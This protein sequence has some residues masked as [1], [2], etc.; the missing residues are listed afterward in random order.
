MIS[1]G[2]ATALRVMTYNIRYD[3]TADGQNQWSNRKANVFQLIKDR[4]PDLLGIQEA[5]ARQMTDLQT[6]L[7]NYRHYGVGRD[8]GNTRGEYSAIFYRADRFD[9]LKSGTFWLSPT[10]TIV[11]SKGWDAAITRICSW[12]Q[13]R[14]KRT[15]Q[16]LYHFNTHYDHKGENARLQS[17]HL[18]LN[19]IKTIAGTTTPVIFTGDLNA[20]PNSD[21][22]R[23]II[24]NTAFKDSYSISEIPH[25]GPNGTFSTFDVSNKMGDRID[26]IFST[27]HF[28][29]L[30]HGALTDS[31]DG[32]YPSDH[33]PVL[34]EVII[35]TDT[36]G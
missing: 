6:A 14:D 1:K 35:K 23:T 19:Q 28:K 17:S 8:D 2:G 18:I 11:G 26:Y 12:I 5:L 3:T 10:P 31:N 16:V 15:Q 9:L 7:P 22:Y 25:C 33:I 29:V 24:T 32:F 20:T 30:Q 27:S 36:S 13:I 21:P 34:A 4:T